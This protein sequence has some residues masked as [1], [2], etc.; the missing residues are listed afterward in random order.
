MFTPIVYQENWA[1]YRCYPLYGIKIV[2]Q[3]RIQD[4]PLWGWGRIF[5]A[6]MYKTKMLCKCVDLHPNSNE[7]QDF[8]VVRLM[9]AYGLMGS[10][11]DTYATNPKK[12][13]EG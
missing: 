13:S 5:S 12:V 11:S 9:E 7:K 1:L 6:K 3:G 10:H 4:F 2:Q 8:Y